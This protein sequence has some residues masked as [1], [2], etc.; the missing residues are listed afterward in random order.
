MESFARRL[1][2]RTEEAVWHRGEAYV[3]QGKVQILKYDEKT[4]EATVAGTHAYHVILKYVTSGIRK[5]CDC[6]Y[7]GSGICKHIVATAIVWDD[8][9]GM[10]RPDPDLVH[11]DT[12]QPR[13]ISRR[14][15][16]RCYADPLNA[17]LDIIRIAADYFA[18]SHGPHAVLPRCPRIENSEKAPLLL[19]EVKGALREMVSWTRRSQYHHYLC[20]GEMAAAFSELLDIICRRLPAT[21]PAEAVRIMLYCADWYYNK[22]NTIA[23]G[24][25]GVWVFPKTR[26][27]RNVAILLKNHPDLP[28]WSAFDRAVYA[29]GLKWDGADL[30][31]KSV[32]EWQ[33][34]RL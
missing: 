11:A 25:D 19:A 13:P 15:V 28:E 1:L 4:V 32:A 5:Q 33:D 18:F 34:G 12:I 3:A 7:A 30:N 22:F 31:A 21:L 2:D 24:S 20:A 27:G 23:D 10:A 26:I 16:S 29:L 14:Q 6:P 8:L 9:R 17:D